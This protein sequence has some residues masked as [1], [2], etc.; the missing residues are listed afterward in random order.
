MRDS[1]QTTPQRVNRYTSTGSWKCEPGCTCRR[2]APSR[3][4]N[5]RTTH[6]MTGTPTYRSWSG[7]RERCTNP[8]HPKF[9][10][11]GGRGIEMCESWRLSFEQ[12]LEDM[13]ERPP[14][15]TLDRVDN[16][17]GYT[18]TNCRWASHSEQQLNRSCRSL[19]LDQE[20]EVVSLLD[21]GWSQSRIAR[22]FG[23][24]R[25]PIA[26]IV[27]DMEALGLDPLT[28]EAAA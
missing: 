15:T 4:G 25:S 22:H 18:P 23:V 26:R 13:G 7:A 6:G 28:G 5:F 14:G 10:R 24:S 1:T 19:T 16:D 3:R 11:Y 17:G 8:N 20:E 2:H 27:R 21:I 9:D 12:F